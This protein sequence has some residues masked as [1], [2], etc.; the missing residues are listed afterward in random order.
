MEKNLNKVIIVRHAESIANTRGIY[1]G[2]SYDTDLSSL[3]R[4]QAMAL[5]KR[6]SELGV[7]KVISSP[8]KRAYYTA[9][10]VSKTLNC[11]LEVEESVVEISHGIWEGKRKD[12]IEKNYPELYR[13]WMSR[14][15]RVQFPEGEHFMDTVRRVS[16][17]LQGSSLSAGTVIVTHDTILRIFICLANGQH[18]DRIWEWKIEP[19]TINYFEFKERDGKRELKLLKLN[20]N[21]HL[22]DL[23]GDLSRHAL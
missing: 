12:W 8:L 4:K 2:Q 21:T 20:D 19:A 9:V 5:A 23:G 1:Q 18:F 13:L 16:K 22:Q 3:G 14:P 7:K 17:F 15:S 6:L 11:S 10:E